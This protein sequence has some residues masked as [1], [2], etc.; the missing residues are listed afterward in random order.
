M[1]RKSLAARVFAPVLFLCMT[2]APAASSPAEMGSSDAVPVI[3]VPGAFFRPPAGEQRAAATLVDLVRA[4][5]RVT[6]AERHDLGPLSAPEIVLLKTRE[7]GG[8]QRVKVGIV[9]I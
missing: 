8:R 7:P 9:R 3:R 5:A 6:A 4:P 2:V 1:R